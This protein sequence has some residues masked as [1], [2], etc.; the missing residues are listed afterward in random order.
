MRRSV[1]MFFALAI[2]LS[3]CGDRQENFVHEC[4][5]ESSFEEATTTELVEIDTD[6]ESHVSQESIPYEDE[7]K[8]EDTIEVNVLTQEEMQIWNAWTFVESI[9]VGWNLGDSLESWVVKESDYDVDLNQERRWGNPI[10][11]QELIDYVAS[12]GFN[13]IRIPVTWYC[14][15]GRDETGRLIIG[16]QWLQRVHQVVDYAVNNDMYVIINTMH[17]SERLFRCGVEDENEWNKI[18]NDAEDLWSQIAE[19]FS[20]YDEKLIFEAYN[21]I[22]NAVTGF[23]YSDLSAE[24]MNILNQIFVDTV[25][26]TG[27]NN[28]ERI[29]MVPTLFD[30][31]RTNIMDAFLLPE[32][33]AEDKIVVTVHSYEGEFDQSIEWKFQTIEDFSRRV[34]APVIIGEFGARDTYTLIEWRE[35]HTSNYIARAASHGIKCCIWD[36]GYHWKIVDRND[37]SQT[38]MDMINAIFRGAEGVAY[39]VDDNNRM[40]L[41]STDDFYFGAMNWN[42]GVMELVDYEN[43]YWAKLTTKTRDDQFHT[44]PECDYISVAMVTKGEAVDFWIYC[45]YFLDEN[46]Q[47]ISHKV[48]KSLMHRFLCAEVPEEAKY[49]VVNTYDPYHNHKLSQI[50]QYMEQGDLEMCITFINTEDES[51]LVEEKLDLK[52]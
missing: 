46:Q 10:V 38:N 36:D 18:Q 13:T 33:S 27:G 23:T 26:E 44:I 5:E 24:Q 51:F 34:N 43:K 3:A 35:E 40:V 47:K 32:D 8:T 21:E 52:N 14:N 19:S 6:L 45:L 28:Q 25:R 16:E 17:D 22:D 2:S 41:N 12:L 37:F 4:R 50:Q 11:S 39:R 7:S 29:L 30:S 31:T 1:V 48:G 15:S 49:F 20:E 42:R 9:N